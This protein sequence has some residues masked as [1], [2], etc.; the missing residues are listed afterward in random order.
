MNKVG[1]KHL[2]KHEHNNI[3]LKCVEPYIG[4][5]K[6]DKFPSNTFK[7]AVLLAYN[8]MQLYLK[9]EIAKDSLVELSIQLRNFSD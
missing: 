1:I 3:I 9:K 7:E 4:F 8:Y 6:S 2:T 5:I